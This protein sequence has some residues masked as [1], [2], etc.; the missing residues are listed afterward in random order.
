MDPGGAEEHAATGQGTRTARPTGDHAS[1]AAR[2]AGSQPTRVG[3]APCPLVP[4]DIQ[5]RSA[6]GRQAPQAG[7]HGSERSEGPQEEP[8]RGRVLVRLC[9]LIGKLQF[10]LRLLIGRG[11]AQASPAR[12]AAEPEGGSASV[13]GHQCGSTRPRFEGPAEGIPRWGAIGGLPDARQENWGCKVLV[14]TGSTS[15]LIKEGVIRTQGWGSRVV[16]CECVATTVSGPTPLR[17]EIELPLSG[18]SGKNRTVV[19]HVMDWSSNEYEAILGTDA[20]KSVKSQIR[21]NGSEWQVRLGKFRYRPEGRV[22]LKSYVGAAV[23]R[24]RGLITRANVHEHFGEVFHREG[25]FLSATGRVRHEIVIPDDRVVYVKPRR[26]PQALTEVM[27]KEVRDLLAQGI[28]RKSVSPYCSPLWVVPKTP[29][30]Q[31]NPRYRVV[32]DLKVLNKYTRPKKYPLPRLEEMLDRMS[33]ASIFSLLDLKAGYHQIRMHEADCEKTAFQFGRGKYEFTRMPFGLRNAPTTFQRLM[34]EFL[35][36]LNEDAIQIYMDDIIVFSR[37]EQEHGRHLGQLLQ[38]LKEFGL[39]ASCEKSS[40]FNESVKFMGHV[41]SREGIRPDPGKVEAI[42]ELQEPVDVKGVRSI[43]GLVGYYRRF[44][45][46][47]ADRM[48]GWNSLT[49]KGAKFVITEDMRKALEW[50]KTRLCEDPVLRFPNFSLPFVITTDASQVAVGAVL[51][52]VDSGG[53]RPVA[54]ASKKLTPAESRYNA[55]ERELLGVVWAVEHFRPYVWG[56]QFQIKTDHKPL[57]WVEGLKET[58]ARITRWKER[59]ASYTFQITHTKGRDNVVA[60]CLS[61]MVN[62]IDSPSPTLDIHEEVTWDPENFD[63]S[64]LGAPERESSEPPG[65]GLLRRRVEE[66]ADLRRRV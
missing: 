35:E 7:A 16:P 59:L 8:P 52:Q 64:L 15:T 29:D 46:S 34:D 32:V 3:A 20:L 51:S 26:Y 21:M 60:D 47:L 43:M 57:V 66:G 49:K 2:Q 37:S 50:A 36:G 1:G 28:I 9:R 23:V 54:Y 63:L 25:E 45:P 65:L 11:L 41:L 17:G 38:R 56:R 12:A 18:L 30:A 22:M 42:R 61:R 39:K 27:E 14:D 24:E 31:G 6:G 33:G 44:L 5:A 10:Q 55:I 48:E 62:A 13:G 4:A 53:D 40:F 58:S 19:A